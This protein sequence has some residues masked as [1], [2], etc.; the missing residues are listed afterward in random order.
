MNQLRKALGNRI[1]ELRKARK[2]TQE[3]LAAEAGL[4]ST[5][6]GGIERGERNVSIDNVGKIAMALKVEPLDLFKF[7]PKRSR[8]EVEKELK[9]RL[10][11]HDPEVVLRILELLEQN[12]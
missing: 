9:Q 5:Y 4:H 6:V 10:A 7:R 2:M 3:D 1:R 11:K 12:T 8:A